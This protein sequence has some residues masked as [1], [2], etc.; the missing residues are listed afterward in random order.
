MRKE[1]LWKLANEMEEHAAA[2]IALSLVQQ[3]VE[4]YVLRTKFLALTYMGST[5]SA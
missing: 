3:L 1:K 2:N 4:P 5:D